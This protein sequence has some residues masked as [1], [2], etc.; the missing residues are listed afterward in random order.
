MAQKTKV[1]KIENEKSRDYGKQFLIEEMSAWSAYDW[2]LRA[3]LAL[4]KNGIKIPEE[5]QDLGIVGL[6]QMGLNAL[7]GANYGDVK[8]LLDELLRCAK[9]IPDNNKDVS[10][11]ILEVDMQEI[12]TIFLLH[13]EAFALH[14]DFLADSAL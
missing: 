6:A 1:F 9:I 5:V 11:P 4:A 2:A 8:P 10:R 7:A 13:K 12:S 3:F 14:A